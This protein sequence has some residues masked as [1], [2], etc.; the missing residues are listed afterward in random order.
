M[1]FTNQRTIGQWL[2][3][4]DLFTSSA[5]IILVDNF[6]MDCIN[7][8]PET[9]YAE[10]HDRFGIKP[11]PSLADKVNGGCAFLAS[12][13]YHKSLEAFL[14]CNKVFNF[15]MVNERVLP[16]NSLDDV[17]WGVTEGRLLEGPEDFA[18][19][20]FSHDIAGY[21]ARILS[22]EGITKPPESLSFAEFDPSEVD[23]RDAALAGD[24][25][26]A[27]AYW[28]RQDGQSR[29]LSQ[30]ANARMEALKAQLNALPL[31]DK[32]RPEL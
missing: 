10:I 29:Q 8:E 13:L 4:P 18:K 3:D 15:K 2:Q 25:I 27:E 11:T 19:A 32:V 1:A 20:G 16:Y 26:A 23:M 31:K 21:V 7:W 24:V 28:Q 30:Y 14:A 6:G 12:D 17:M 5:V 22:V 9:L